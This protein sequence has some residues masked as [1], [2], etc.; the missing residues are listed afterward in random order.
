MGY[1]AI[2][3][4]EKAILNSINF[5]KD[6]LKGRIKESEIDSGLSFAVDKVMGEGA[7]YTKK[8]AAKAIK[9]SGGDLLNAAFFVRA[10]RSAC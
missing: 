3:G 7:L 2:K 8:L 4:G 1:V 6:S 9:M 5:Y 10:H